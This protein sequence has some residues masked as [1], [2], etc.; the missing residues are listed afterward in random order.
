MTTRKQKKSGIGK[1][2]LVLIL[3]LAVGAGLFLILRDYRPAVT[4][5]IPFGGEDTDG[6]GIPDGL[7]VSDPETGF[8]RRADVYN[9]LVLGVD[10][11]ANLADVILLVQFDVGQKNLHLV[12][13]PRDAYV[14]VGSNYHKINAY[15]ASAYNRSSSEGAKR[16][17]DAALALKSFLEAGFCVK[18]DRYALMDLEG[19]RKIVDAIGGVEMDVPYDMDY[20]DPEQDLY[21]HLKAGYQ[22]LDGER[23]EQFVRFRKGYLNGDIG[24]ISAQRLFLL[25]FAKK[26]KSS[27]TVPAAISLAPTVLPYLNTDISAGEAA[28]FGKEALSL[29]YEYITFTTIPGGGATNPVSG[30]S[31]Y[32]LYAGAVRE[33]VN[34]YLNVYEEE[35][36][37]ELFLSSSTSFTSPDS[38][39]RDIFLTFPYGEIDTISGAELARD[40]IDV[41]LR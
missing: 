6:N 2:L 36:S 12:S 20:E 23:A 24:R 26:L 25:S 19:F 27:L 9:L 35:I 10:R 17:S 31:Y 3:A 1:F 40:G 37:E 16:I 18:I 5:E 14:N 22:L 39:I 41:P 30:A 15:F 34:R 8:S 33:I 38:Y 11:A 29:E 21:I 13:V 4:P 32:V 7:T 28:Y